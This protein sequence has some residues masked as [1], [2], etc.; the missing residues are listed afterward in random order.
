LLLGASDTEIAITYSDFERS[1][2]LLKAQH[3]ADA[4]IA[5]YEATKEQKPITWLGACERS[6]EKNFFKFKSGRPVAN[7]YFELHE[8]PGFR[9]R[10]C[11]RGKQSF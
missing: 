10:R 5:L 4:L 9:F 2:A 7:W 1:N 3:V 8:V 6:I 11:E